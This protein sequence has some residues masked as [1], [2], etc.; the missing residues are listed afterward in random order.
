MMARIHILKTLP[1]VVIGLWA[2][3]LPAHDETGVDSSSPAVAASSPTVPASLPPSSAESGD[4]QTALLHAAPTLRPDALGA[5]LSAWDALHARGEVA[6]PLLSV[7][8]YSLPST[9]KR[10][11]VFDLGSRR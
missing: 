1:L 11:W 9:A 3:A 5:A 6:R 2:A 8:D 10:M 4:L 7:I